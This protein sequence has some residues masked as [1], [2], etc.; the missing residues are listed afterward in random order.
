LERKVAHDDTHLV[1]LAAKLAELEQENA[2]LRSI[3]VGKPAEA[4]EDGQ[5]G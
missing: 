4:S 1:N 2:V 5:R 3:L